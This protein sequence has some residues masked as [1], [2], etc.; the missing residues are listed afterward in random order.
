[1]LV[2]LLTAYLSFSQTGT[3]S[4]DTLICKPARIM[5]LIAIDVQ[6][7]DACKLLLSDRNTEI[8][9]LNKHIDFADSLI[10]NQEK[11]IKNDSVVR[12]SYVNL[13]GVANANTQEFKERFHVVKTND[14]IKMGVGGA[15]IVGLIYALIT[16]K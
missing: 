10:E 14:R 7:G 8:G 15:L 6:N 13:L 11:T 4:K 5:R 16:K 3:G 1:M 12:V 2:C 9:L